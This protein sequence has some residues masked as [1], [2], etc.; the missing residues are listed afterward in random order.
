[1]STEY[2]TILKTLKA[3]ANVYTTG[4]EYTPPYPIDIQTE[5]DNDSSVVKVHKAVQLIEAEEPKKIVKK[6]AKK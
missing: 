4:T 1:M 3:G 6:R 2:C 5:I